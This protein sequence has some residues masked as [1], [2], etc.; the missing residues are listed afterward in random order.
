MFDILKPISE[1]D[2]CGPDLRWDAEFMRFNSMVESLL[3][4]MEVDDTDDEDGDEAVDQTTFS[5]I[6]VLELAEELLER[7]KDVGLA[8]SRAEIYWRSQGL[9]AFL[10]AM[11]DLA[12]MIKAWAGP[13]DG[14]HPRADPEDG[15]LFE[16]SAGIGK[17]IRSIPI[18]T[19]T[20]GWGVN[21]P[22]LE[23]QN[24][25]KVIA[26]DIFTKWEDLFGTALGDGIPSAREAWQAIKMLLPGVGATSEGG[27]DQ[28]QQTGVA[29]QALA[30]VIVD[31]WEL[32]DKAVDRMKEQDRHSPS[33]PL[34]RMILSW[35]DMG[36]EEIADVMKQSGVSLEQTLDSIRRME[37]N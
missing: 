23:V 30:P 13:D 6:E 7:T 28:L 5:P 1:E 34:L 33:I 14:V 31:A 25:L 36:I 17:L 2:P 18:L 3:I 9:E 16:R 20:K 22:D 35:R 24:E 10:R 29:G 11:D 12:K 37:K 15:D 26:E 19:K 21:T 4:Q 27:G 32:L 8:V